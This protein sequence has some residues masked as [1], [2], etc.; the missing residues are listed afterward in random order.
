MKILSLKFTNI[1][2]LK[3]SWHIDFSDPEF[4]TNGIFAITGQTGAGK[5]TILDA[6][7]LAIY[8]QTPRIKSISNA[9]NDVMSLDTGECASEVEVA[10]GDKLY[11]FGWEQRRAGKKS[12][13]NLQPIKREISEIEC[14]GDDSGNILEEK[15]SRCDKLT[16]QLMRMN[17]E[18]F[19]RS[20]MLAQ[21]NF[22]AFLKADAQEKG[23]ILEQITGTDIYGKIS[24]KTHEIT[25]EKKDALTLLESKISE[26]VV[27][28][29]DEFAALSQEITDNETS[30]KHAQKTLAALDEKLTAHAN[31]QRA[32]NEINKHQADIHHHQ[33]ALDEFAVDGEILAQAERAALIEPSYQ[34]CLQ[35]QNE[36]AHSQN[37]VN[38]LST[39]LPELQANFDAA[40]TQKQHADDTLKTEQHALQTALPIIKNARTLDNRLAQLHD[41]ISHSQD[42]INR[43]Q[44]TI[45]TAKNALAAAISEQNEQQN[46]LAQIQNELASLPAHANA[47][48]DLGVL[49]GLKQ[50]LALHQS[51]LEKSHATIQDFAQELRQQTYAINEKRETLKQHKNLRQTLENDYHTLRQDTLSLLQSLRLDVAFNGAHLDKHS[52]NSLDNLANISQAIT[53]ALKSLHERMNALGRLY[54]LSHLLSQHSERLRTLAAEHTQL[55]AQK[56]TL[57]TALTQHEQDKDNINA[58][59]LA[60]NDTLA[61]LEQTQTLRQELDVLR[62][63]FAKLT[64]NSPCA[65]CGS[66]TH[67]YKEN[68]H[69]PFSQANDNDSEQTQNAIA[70]AKRTLDE[71][72]ENLRHTDAQIIAKRTKLELLN[73][74]FDK[75]Q[76]QFAHTHQEMRTTH[77]TLTEL[78]QKQQLPEPDFS[79]VSVEFGLNGDFDLQDGFGL[80]DSLTANPAHT[81]TPT[82]QNLSPADFEQLSACHMAYQ[83]ELSAYGTLG[84]EIGKLETLQEQLANTERALEQKHTQITLTTQEGIALKERIAT[85]ERNIHGAFADTRHIYAE[86]H[87]LFGETTA[88]IGAHTPTDV[89]PALMNELQIAMRTLE[90]DT[91]FTQPEDFAKL[92]Q[93]LIT[94]ASLNQAANTLQNAHQHITNLAKHTDTLQQKQHALTQTLASIGAHITH[95][96]A[97]IQ[98]QTLAF[99]DEKATLAKLQNEFSAVKQERQALFAETADEFEQRLYTAQTFAQNK[100][101]QANEK[102]HFAERQLLSTKERL[103]YVKA[104]LAAQSAQLIT[105]NDA[106]T[107]QLRTQNFDDEAQFLS[108]R[109]PQNERAALQ[110][111]QQ[112]LTQNLAHAKALLAT[113]QTNIDEILAQNPELK[114]QNFDEL[115]KQ[116]QELT[117]SHYAL[118]ERQGEAKERHQKAKNERAQNQANLKLL[119]DKKQDFTVWAKL[120]E[121]IGSANGKKYRNFAQ[122]LTLEFMLHHANRVLAQ[123]S[124]R[125]VLTHS[126]D[127]DKGQLDISVIDTA[128]G[129]ELRSTKN[130]SGGESFVI[131]LALAMGLSQLN[132]EHTTINSLF[133]DEGFGTLDDE[134]LDTALSVLASFKDEGKM[135]GVISHVAALKER[136]PTQIHVKKSV[137][138]RS[139]LHGAGVVNCG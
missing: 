37:E 23:E 13:G 10:I 127:D 73:D 117:A 123:M 94:P 130:L 32:T 56:L 104:Q 93:A 76:T 49:T 27:M 53:P 26:Q 97:Q 62:A 65:L 74:E 47:H 67:P 113:W 35:K 72:T 14:L 77:H 16:E 69:N 43:Q 33:S 81:K 89:L 17:F 133:L 125:Y 86:L 55:N 108:A 109:L 135:I 134:I 24:I 40:I 44:N 111:K 115:N 18:Q 9:Q 92:H 105:L 95:S 70:H 38:E 48:Q 61:A 54:D 2:S 36:Q 88:L 4:T 84:N 5:T 131:S 99:N 122:G 58:Q 129:S 15:A 128:Q 30:I 57:S 3:G 78:A 46:L 39:A 1:H 98:E 90:A 28:S 20:V 11:R 110:T 126:R 107:E 121:L 83:N 137:G 45:N 8:G 96:E 71:L 102:A 75:L 6:I 139:T 64:P 116:K 79:S 7:C 59:I 138:G 66:L 82:V 22:A 52:D 112:T 120:N 12:D 63:Q 114:T 29:D 19:T 124:E 80:Q 132:S 101:A 25:R 42:T 118:L 50:K 100:L 51:Q 60:Q 106:F 34:E 41:K 103:D 119:A 21:G 87:T 85:L 136:I 91:K 31:W 68:N